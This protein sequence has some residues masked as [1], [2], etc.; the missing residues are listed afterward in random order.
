MFSWD[1]RLASVITSSWVEELDIPFLWISFGN[2]AFQVEYVLTLLG[3]IYQDLYPMPVHCFEIKDGGN[4][5]ALRT[6]LFSWSCLPA[7]PGRM[8]GC[9]DQKWIRLIVG[10]VRAQVLRRGREFLAPSRPEDSNKSRCFELDKYDTS[11]T[12]DL[13]SKDVRS[14]AGGSDLVSTLGTILPA[15]LARYNSYSPQASK[16]EHDSMRLLAPNVSAED[17]PSSRE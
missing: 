13:K 15:R 7:G 10:L 17:R 9:N 3:H 8:L 2:V 4:V 14:Q 11:S 5:S 6:V 12:P 1:V 16:A